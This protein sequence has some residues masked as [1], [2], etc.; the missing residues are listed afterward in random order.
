MRTVLRPSR[1]RGFPRSG[2]CQLSPRDSSEQQTASLGSFSIF[3]KTRD[4][5]G[6]S[7]AFWDT[8]AK[9]NREGHEETREGSHEGDSSIVRSSSSRLLFM[10][11]APFAGAF[12]FLRSACA[13]DARR[14]R[15]TTLAPSPDGK[16]FRI[17]RK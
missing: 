3:V 10:S 7:G 13:F 12:L 8:E 14:A 4:I 5:P 11:F 1:G 9:G 15:K 6:H 17:F 2:R 16:Y